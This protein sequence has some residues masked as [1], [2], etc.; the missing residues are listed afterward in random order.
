MD[1]TEETFKL[2]TKKFAILWHYPLF[3]IADNQI[4][5]SNVCIFIIILLLGIRY[6][7]R[8]SNFI[9]S[10]TI[11][12]LNDNTTAASNLSKVIIY[13]TRILYIIIAMAV[14]NI[15][16]G[17]LTIIGGAL[18]FGLGFGTQNLI[19][20]F[21]SGLIIMI[22]QPIKV[23]DVIAIKG[24]VGKVTSIGMRCIIIRTSSN[25]DVLIPS[26][27]VIL[28]NV[29]NW[30]LNK[31][32]VKYQI[33]IVLHDTEATLNLE[34]FMQQ[35]KITIKGLD[36]IKPNTN[37]NVFLIKVGSNNLTFLIRFDMDIKQNPELERIQNI[38]NLLF[39]S[40]LKNY[41]FSLDHLLEYK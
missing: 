41:N 11:N 8:F 5:V 40:H 36:F 26:S 16:I 25:N 32:I 28:N 30:T 27:E 35:L 15:P 9:N 2:V 14:A 6:S 38:L 7:K 20:N 18:F 39:Y 17:S 22:E 3:P 23:G 29:T 24:V 34:D 19:T 13:I 10:Y 1:Q 37:I 33:E 31:D 12:K 21:I 4:N